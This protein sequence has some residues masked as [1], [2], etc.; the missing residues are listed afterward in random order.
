MVDYYVQSIMGATEKR[1][2]SGAG[3]AGIGDIR[4]TESVWLGGG[5]VYQEWEEGAWGQEW[6]SGFTASYFWTC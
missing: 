3:V 1:R 4:G 2:E 5:G 6:Q